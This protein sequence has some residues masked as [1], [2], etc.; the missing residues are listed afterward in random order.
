MWFSGGDCTP[1]SRLKWP[2]T[3]T[4]RGGNNQFYL[5]PALASCVFVCVCVRGQGEAVSVRVGAHSQDSRERPWRND[6]VWMRA[7]PGRPSPFPEAARRVTDGGEPTDW[8]ASLNKSRAL[9]HPIVNICLSA[10][11]VPSSWRSSSRR[12]RLFDLLDSSEGEEKYET[13]RPARRQ[14]LGEIRRDELLGRPRRRRAGLRPSS[15][16]VAILS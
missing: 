9:C 13:R 4:A 5:A 3:L 2:H 15:C 14:K 16:H 11:V 7:Q 6:R 8:R 10:S 1:A 12:R